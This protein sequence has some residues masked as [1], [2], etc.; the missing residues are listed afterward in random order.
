MIR[1]LSLLNHLP[2]AIFLSL[3]LG[4]PLL[5]NAVQASVEANSAFIEAPFSKKNSGAGFVLMVSLQRA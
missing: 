3:L 1:F 5:V 2:A 4:S